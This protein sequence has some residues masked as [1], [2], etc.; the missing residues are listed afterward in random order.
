MKNPCGPRMRRKRCH[1]RIA[2]A[3]KKADT[4]LRYKED[5][6][7]LFLASLDRDQQKRAME[8]KP[9]LEAST[10]SKVARKCCDRGEN[11]CAICM[12]ELQPPKK[13]KQ[14]PL[15][16]LSCSHVFHQNCL[17]ACEAFATNTKCPICRQNYDKC[18]W[19]WGAKVKK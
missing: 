13:M 15:W 8:E 14:R 7:D 4:H 16:L 9:P 2:F 17:N 12:Q 18:A 6:L 1:K 19:R 10:W 3:S 5:A 11:E